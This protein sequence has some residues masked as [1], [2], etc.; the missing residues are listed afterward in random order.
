MQPRLPNKMAFQTFD[1][2]EPDQP[3]YKLLQPPHV[4]QMTGACF[5]SAQTSVRNKMHPT[6]LHGHS[7]HGPFSTRNSTYATLA[8]SQSWLEP[9]PFPPTTSPPP[10]QHVP[11]PAITIAT[12]LPAQR[13][14][15]IQTISGPL[16][17]PQLLPAASQGQAV[18]VGHGMDPNQENIVKINN[19]DLGE[20]T[21][22]NEDKTMSN[23]GGVAG[24]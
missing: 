18:A 13:A 4:A 2:G 8:P 16:A 15:P 9:R 14:L 21:L 1:A 11:A 3:R 6:H 23:C 12:A 20:S 17:A 22:E 7:H 19:L 5:Q 10:P 24:K